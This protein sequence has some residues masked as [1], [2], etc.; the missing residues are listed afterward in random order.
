[1]VPLLRALAQEGH[2]VHG[3]LFIPLDFEDD[4]RVGG[5]LRADL[6]EAF[7]SDSDGVT[8]KGPGCKTTHAQT[9]TDSSTINGWPWC[10]FDRRCDCCN[11]SFSAEADV[12]H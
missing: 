11:T 2:I 5:V 7:A 4:S 12:G 1:M 9:T 6:A 10:F 8:V 3:M